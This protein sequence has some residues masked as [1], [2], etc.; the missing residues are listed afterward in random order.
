[1]GDAYASVGDKVKAAQAF[2]HSKA[3]FTILKLPQMVKA[4]EEMMEQAGL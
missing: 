2:A 3:I 4:V 1:M